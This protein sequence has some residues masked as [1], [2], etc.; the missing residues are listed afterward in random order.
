MKRFLLFLTISLRGCLQALA[1]VEE[2]EALVAKDLESLYD[3][4]EEVRAKAAA[5]LRSIIARYPSGTS[6]L[7][8]KDSGEAMWKKR[9]SKLH[10]GMPWLEVLGRLPPARDMSPLPSRQDYNVSTVNFRVDKHYIIELPAVKNMTSVEL[11]NKL[12]TLPRVLVNTSTS[13]SSNDKDAKGLVLFGL[14]RLVKSEM[15]IEVFPEN[16]FTGEMTSWYANGQRYSVCNYK[17][18]EV[19]GS[20]TIFNSAGRKSHV[21]YY[22]AGLLQR[23]AP[24][25][26]RP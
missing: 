7:R 8:H 2:D 20:E 1:T 15:P 18:G 19:E 16:E 10:S 12:A 25:A 21:E 22:H 4:H 26:T 3:A 17:N 14:P 11:A 5:Q 9:L 13:V 6:D 23:D 24:N